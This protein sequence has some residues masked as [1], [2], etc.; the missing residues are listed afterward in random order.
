MGITRR[1]FIRKS[2]GIAAI[3]AIGDLFFNLDKV[4]AEESLKKIP[5]SPEE[6]VLIPSTDMMC[7]NF[8]GIRVRRVNG[9]IRAIYGN[10][11]SPYNRGHLCPKGQS[12][13]F[14]TYNPY[15]LKAPLKRTNPD[16]SPYADPKWKEISWEEAFNEIARKLREVREKDPRGLTFHWSHGKYLIQDKFLKAFCRAFGTPNNVH[17]TTVCEAA[18]HIADELTWGGHGILPDLDYTKYYINMGSNFTEAEQWARWLDRTCMRRIVDEGMKMVVVE[19]RLS[20]TGSKASEWIPIRPGKDVIFLLAMAKELIKMGY[21]DEEFLRNYTDAVF[22]VGDDGKFLKDGSGN[23]LVWDEFKNRAVPY[24]VAEKIALDKEV[25][26]EKKKYRTSFKVFKDQVLSL[27]E[28]EVEEI[29]G[30]PYETIKRIA[31]EFGENAKIGSTIELQGQKLRY[32]PVAIHTFRGLSAKEY[33][34]QNWRAGLIVNMLVGSIDAVGGLLLHKANPKG[35]NMKPSRCEYP[36][37]RVDLAGSVFY[38]HA[39]HNVA[40]QPAHTYANP[41]KYGLPYKPEMAI[42]YGTNRVLSTSDINKQIEGFKKVYSVDINVVLDE[43]AQMADIVLPDK[44]YLETWQYSYTRWTPDSSHKAIRQPIVNTFGLRYDAFEILMELAERAGFLDEFIDEINKIWKLKGK[45]FEKGRKYDSKS[46]VKLLW[47]SQ[48]GKPFEYA[49]EHGLVS[50]KVDVKKRYLSN[51]EK[52]RGRGKPKM[53]F[54]AEQLVHTREKVYQ[55]MEKK[56]NVKKVFMEW[57]EENDEKSLKALLESKFSPL[58]L[59]EHAFPTPHRKRDRKEFPFYLIT[60]KRMYRNQTDAHAL[61][62][63][64]NEVA[65]DSDTNFVLINPKAAENLGIEDGDDVYVESKI[66]K[67]KAKAKLTHGI[68]IDTVAVSYHYGRFSKAFPKYAKKGT[69]P[70]FVIEYHPDIISG[71]NSFN[72]TLVKVYKA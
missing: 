54:Y 18:R 1:E 47:E 35:K 45:K 50:K 33:G 11:E 39:T 30:V 13:I 53:H 17:R 7:V 65:H 9:V 6:D 20:N 40:Q 58:P 63:I 22:L 48:T 14:H 64:L 55:I 8:C 26:I 61:N 46:A 62:P 27:R 28:R 25:E 56:D 68:R 38:P 15:R 37:S 44:T 69:M 59:K 49:V 24:D 10:P 12:G 66:G 5:F 21:I 36:P 34:V 16:K 41:E 42:F 2:M 67:V 57:Y 60:Y 43:T 52:Y 51:A 70:N 71:H 4:V 72:D 32:R 29:T 19:P 31:R 23:P 3:A